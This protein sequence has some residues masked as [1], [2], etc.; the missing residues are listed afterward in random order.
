MV[1]DALIERVPFGALVNPATKRLLVERTAPVIAPSASVYVSL[2]AVNETARATALVAADSE[3]EHLPRLP[4]ARAEAKEIASMYR[5]E[6]LVGKTARSE[7]FL[8][9]L[10]TADLLHVGMHTFISSTDPMESSILMTSGPV[11]VRDLVS[12]GV[13]R[14]SIAVLAGCRTAKGS[15]QADIDSLALA[16]L[17]A[18]SRSS[19]GS[20]WDVD[21]DPTRHFSVRLHQ[22]LRSGTL[23]SQAVRRVQLEMLRSPDRSL[24]DVR[25]WA[26]FQVYGSG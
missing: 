9:R 4:A 11:R 3:L 15:G 5:S 2:S 18:G 13:R 21:D 12:R 1:P 23:A 19:V 17:A 8:E 24:S 25:S 22:L 26:A 16:F 14:G 20:L 7:T 10:D 6:A